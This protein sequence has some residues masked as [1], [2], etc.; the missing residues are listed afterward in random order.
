MAGS[1]KD[2][3]F[4]ERKNLIEKKPLNQILSFHTTNK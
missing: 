3:H 1:K 4:R 2:E